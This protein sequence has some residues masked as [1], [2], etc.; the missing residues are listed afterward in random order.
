MSPEM[1]QQMEMDEMMGGLSGKKSMF[2]GKKRK[3]K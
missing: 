3:G 1:E 2:G